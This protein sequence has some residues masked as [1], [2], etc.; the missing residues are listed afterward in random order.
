MKMIKN[1]PQTISCQPPGPLVDVAL[2]QGVDARPERLNQPGPGIIQPGGEMIARA[3]RIGEQPCEKTAVSLLVNALVAQPQLACDLRRVGY[4]D[5]R[6]L[7]RDACSGARRW[8]DEE[9]RCV[10]VPWQ[11]GQQRCQPQLRRIRPYLC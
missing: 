4:A 3:F 1:M 8:R 6:Q 7:L 11:R 10:A 2:E 9:V 5:L